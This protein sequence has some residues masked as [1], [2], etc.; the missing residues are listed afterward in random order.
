[1]N[2][3]NKKSYVGCMV[4]M[5]ISANLWAN[6]LLNL[7]DDQFVRLL[8]KGIPDEC[9]AY[10][11]GDSHELDKEIDNLKII[12]TPGRAARIATQQEKDNTYSELLGVLEQRCYQD[13]KRAI[14]SNNYYKDMPKDLQV[15]DFSD[16]RVLDRYIKLVGLK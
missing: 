2:H 8:G 16:R 12:D 3:V 11:L 10:Y 14:V 1:M 13:V 5:M 4:I 7:S 6:S 9:I 15:D